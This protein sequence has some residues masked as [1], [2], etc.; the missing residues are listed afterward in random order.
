MTHRMEDESSGY[1]ELARFGAVGAG[2]F[3]LYFASYWVA[4]Q[5]LPDLAAVTFCYLVA[6]SFH[7]LANRVFT[8]GVS[9][10]SSRIDGAELVRYGAVVFIGYL[11]NISGFFISTLGLGLPEAVGLLV[12]VACSTAASFLLL[13]NWVFKAST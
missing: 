7:Y 5:F 11:A 10:K 9:L 1:R 13:R 8:F 2:T 6:I 12:G 3:C 4:E